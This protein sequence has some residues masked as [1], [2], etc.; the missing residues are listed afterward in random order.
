MSE[1][2]LGW[3]SVDGN[4]TQRQFDEIRAALPEAA[5]AGKEIVV[6]QGVTL[7]WHRAESE[8]DYCG[9]SI[10]A[11]HEIVDPEGIESTARIPCPRSGKP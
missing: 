5:A 2:P 6:V 4:L 3:W 7:R 9:D 10:T 8:C 11:W 1:R